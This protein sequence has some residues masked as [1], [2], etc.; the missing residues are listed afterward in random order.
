MLLWVNVYPAF[1][2]LHIKS[3][4]FNCLWLWSSFK[5]NLMYFKKGNFRTESTRREVA[6]EGKIG[7][8]NRLGSHVS[9]A[10]R[11]FS[12]LSEPQFNKYCL[13][14]KQ[15]IESPAVTVVSHCLKFARTHIMCFRDAQ[16]RL[17]VYCKRSFSCGAKVL[18]FTLSLNSLVWTT[19]V[20][21]TVLH[22]IYVR[23]SDERKPQQMLSQ[24]KE[25]PDK[26]W[27]TFFLL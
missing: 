19:W 26:S 8:R 1:Y 18:C 21:T 13:R 11:S 3:K 9:I 10:C 15:D 16:D 6:K 7:F 20:S 25:M 4:I 24:Q 2:L 27:V 12:Y 22:C 17:S 14:A 5:E 23:K